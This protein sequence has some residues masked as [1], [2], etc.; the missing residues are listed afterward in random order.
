M[1]DEA[2]K[3]ITHFEWFRSTSYW[4][5]KQW[6]VWYGTK[7]YQWEIITEQVARERVYDIIKSIRDRHNF[8]QYEDNIEV[9]LISFTYNLGH[10]PKWY[11]WYIQNWHIEALSNRMNEYIYWWW[12]VLWGLVKRRNI[13]WQVVTEWTYILNSM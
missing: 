3:L 11:Q 13:E 4:D 2:F 8:Y 6:S 1:E 10:P 12:K 7:S 9:W 5:I